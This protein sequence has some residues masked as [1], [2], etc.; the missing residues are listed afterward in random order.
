[1][2]GSNHYLTHPPDTGSLLTGRYSTTGN[3]ARISK[4]EGTRFRTSSDTEVL[5]QLYAAY[6]PKC[7][8]MLN[9]QYAFAIWDKMKEELFIAR[10]RMGIRPF[11]YNIHDGVF[12]FASEIKSIFRQESIP[13]EFDPECLSQV[14]TFWTTIT[15]YTAFKNIFEL[16]PGHYGFYNRNGLKT[17]KYWELNFG[18]QWHILFLYFRLWKILPRSSPMLSE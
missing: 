9:G 11:F 1:M 17:V 18:K 12:T 3:Y 5:I 13:K 15:P 14:Y 4:K 2:A 10:D 6:G 16:S 7:L 8:E